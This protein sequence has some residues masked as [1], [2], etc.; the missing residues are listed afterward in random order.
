VVR[1][2]VSQALTGDPQI[3]VVGTA[4]NGVSALELVRQHDPDVVTLDVHM[5]VMDGLET[6]DRL[7]SERPTLPVI[8]FSRLTERGA[9]TT[10]EA[11]LRGAADYVVKPARTEGVEA[12]V[13]AMRAVLLP[14]IVALGG[15][16]AARA[17]ARA[18][19][20]RRTGAALAP[21]TSE[22]PTPTAVQRRPE[23]QI[24]V[25]GVS[26]GGPNALAELI[27]ALPSDLAVPIVIV[28]HMPAMFT[29]LLR[30]RLASLS[31]LEV[32]EA[33]TGA[34]LDRP[35]LWLAPG[36]VHTEVV[37]ESTV[38]TLR[39]A[40]GPEEN[41]CRPSA[42]ILFRS[43]A[44]VYGDEVLAVVLTGM[45]SDGLRGC[46]AIVQ[47]GGNVIAQDESTSVVWGMP[48]A[49]ARE[50]LARVVLPLSAIGGAIGRRV[51]SARP[52]PPLRSAAK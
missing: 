36:G 25:I 14:K 29:R 33:Y 11:L 19:E 9:A 39:L 52:R 37:C 46:E 12:A 50:G 17:Q 24:V 42:D 22:P 34:T 1:G 18:H 40:S 43:A 44:A 10:I 5:P 6:L 31:N 20:A 49:V 48:G 38:P 21:A 23:A 27:P 26:T 7:R 30:E 47:A 3:E 32:A 41:F 28:Q 15:V 45:G 16:A 13:E 8:M 2:L 4:S 35:V 51:V